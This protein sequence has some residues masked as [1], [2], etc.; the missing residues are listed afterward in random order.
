VRILIF[1][2]ITFFFQFSDN[3]S[4]H[5]SHLHGP[6]VGRWQRGTEEQQPVPLLRRRRELQLLL[7]LLD[8]CHPIQQ[9]HP[10][11]VQTSH[12]I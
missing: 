7:E 8:L 4:L 6:A 9:P 2:E 11:Q 1:Y 12:L 3:F 10:H 5:H